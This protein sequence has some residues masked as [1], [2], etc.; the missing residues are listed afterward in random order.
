M[1]ATQLQK[2]LIEAINNELDLCDFY[3]T[4]IICNMKSDAAT[5]EMLIKEIE[6]R[7]LQQHIDIADAIVQIDNE[8]NPNTLD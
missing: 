8:Y 5:R 7:V 2:E 3:E 6:K 4:P 1:D